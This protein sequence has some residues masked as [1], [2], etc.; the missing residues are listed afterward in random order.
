MDAIELAQMKAGDDDALNRW[1]ETN[2]DGL[3]AFIY[4]RVGSNTDLAQDITQSTFALALQK[5]DKYDPERGA[6]LNWLRSA[7]EKALARRRVRP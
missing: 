4:Y 5:L 7:S 6:M 1:F 2:V 3:Y